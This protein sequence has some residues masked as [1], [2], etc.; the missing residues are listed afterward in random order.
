MDP[1]TLGGI[2]G[3]SLVGLTVVGCHIYDRCRHL[4]PTRSRFPPRRPSHW[5][6]KNVMPIHTQPRKGS[7][8]QFDDRNHRLR[9]SRSNGL[10]SSETAIPKVFT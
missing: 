1:G 6:V 2:L 7:Y 8:Y 9:V 3:A 4:P 5:R 10:V